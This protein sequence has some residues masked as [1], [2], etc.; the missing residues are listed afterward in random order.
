MAS[1]KIILLTP[2]TC[3][4]GQIV[5]YRKADDRAATPRSL[6]EAN[7]AQHRARHRLSPGHP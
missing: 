2:H 6:Q 7:W 3:V 5:V 1:T 4:F